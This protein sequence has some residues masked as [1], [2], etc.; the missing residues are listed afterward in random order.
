MF[1]PSCSADRSGCTQ[2]A[3]ER[4]SAHWVRR[5][6]GTNSAK[7]CPS[8]ATFATPVCIVLHISILDF[9]IKVFAINTLAGRTSGTQLAMNV[10]GVLVLSSVLVLRHLGAQNG[11]IGRL[12]LYQGA[13]NDFTQH[14][15]RLAC[16]S[17]CA[18]HCDIWL[19][20]AALRRSQP[21]LLSSMGRRTEPLLLPE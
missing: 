11:K 13:K 7:K 17:V 1:R 2:S 21:N 9:E 20:A 8:L 3:W 19:C 14:S 4:W 12:N 15:H 5:A 10:S 6:R 18:R 16:R